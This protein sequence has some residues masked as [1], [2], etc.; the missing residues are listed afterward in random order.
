MQLNSVIRGGCNRCLTSQEMG[1]RANSSLNTMR[2]KNITNG[3]RRGSNI[4]QTMKPRSIRITYHLPYHHFNINLLSMSHLF[5]F[6]HLL[7]P[8]HVSL[9]TQIGLFITWE[10]WMSHVLIVV[11]GT[12]HVKGCSTLQSLACAVSVERL[13]SQDLTIHHQSFSIFSQ[14]RRLYAR[15]F[16][17]TFAIITMHWP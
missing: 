13:K 3:G 17:I 7:C 5:L 6:I 4:C 15:I 1:S 11:L 16:V 9:L 2:K 14:A 10:E 12:G 8:L